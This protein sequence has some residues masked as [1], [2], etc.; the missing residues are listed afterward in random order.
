VDPFVSVKAVNLMGRANQE[1]MEDV[2]DY[3]TLQE[4][5]VGSTSIRFRPSQLKDS[6]HVDVSQWTTV[7]N[8]GAACY[9]QNVQAFHLTLGLR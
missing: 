1:V 7:P 5:A 6:N 4:I 3:K 2:D 9:G 8:I